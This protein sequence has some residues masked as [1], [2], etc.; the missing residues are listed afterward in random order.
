M[1]TLRAVSLVL[2][3]LVAVACAKKEQPPQA[4][5]SA[6]ASTATAQ[7]DTVTMTAKN[8]SGIT[9]TAVATH[10]ADSTT[11]TVTLSGLKSGSSY[12]THVHQGTCEKPGP[13]VTPLTSVSAGADGSGTSTTTIALGPLDTVTKA[14]NQL[15]VQSHQPDGTPAACGALNLTGS[16]GGMD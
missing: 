7:A 5:S 10:T 12:P 3:G 14:G 8:N 13:V 11:I 16:T 1:R 2:A 6:A 4:A 15:L 9:G